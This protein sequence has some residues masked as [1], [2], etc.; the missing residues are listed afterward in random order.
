MS[1]ISTIDVQLARLRLRYANSGLPKFFAWW[2]REL[3]GMLPQRWRALFAEGA[4]E[5]LVDAKPGQLDVWRQSGGRCSEYGRIARDAAVEDQRNEFLRL[6]D[7][8][9]DPGLRVFYCIA[10]QRALRRELTLPVAAEDKLRQVLAF[11]MDRQTPFKADQVFFDYR[12]VQRDATAKTL[13]VELHVVPRAQID[14]ELTAL[15]G[16]GIALDG[17]DCWRGTPN[18]GRAGLNLL[19]PERRVKRVN[20]RL[21]LNLALGAAAAVLFVVA[22]LLFLNNRQA[23]LDAMSAEVE[24]AKGEAKQ[25]AVLARRLKDNTSSA[26]YLYRLKRDT[27]PMTAMLADLTKRLPDDTFLE[28]LTVDEKGKVEVQGQSGNANKLIEGLQKSEMLDNAAFIGTVQPDVRTKKDRFTMNFQLH[29]QPEP[30][31]PDKD[32]SKPGDKNA[33]KPAEAADA[34]A[35]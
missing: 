33:K 25:T 12:I 34:P 20:Q 24:K 14:G 2:M 35:A 8:I 26:S 10:P 22:G 30:E 16:I 27:T 11:E 13:R 19:P 18:G 3:T 32:A 5:L 21:R 28:R 4:Q 23:G 1:V 17:V 31:A 7:R 6:R 9:D 29:R 15:A